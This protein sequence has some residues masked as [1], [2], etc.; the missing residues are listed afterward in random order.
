MAL[1]D[2]PKYAGEWPQ[3]AKVTAIHGDRV[4]VHW[5]KGSKTTAWQPC[6]R[7]SETGGK[8]VPWTEDVARDTIWLFDFQLTVTGKL[9]QKI[10]EKIETYD[11]L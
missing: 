10:R 6:T 11:C 3:V 8:W 5:F 4:L 1:L 2:V 7:R 9:P